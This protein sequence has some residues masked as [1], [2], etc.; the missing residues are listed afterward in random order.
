V[1]RDY[2]PY[3]WKLACPWCSFYIDVGPRGARGRDPGAGVEAAELMQ[4]HTAH[5]HGKSWRDFLARVK[6]VA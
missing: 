4:D 5:R 6:V 1:S 2:V 3:R